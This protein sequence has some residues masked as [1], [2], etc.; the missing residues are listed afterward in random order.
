V[1]AAP[2]ANG[3]TTTAIVVAGFAAVVASAIVPHYG[4]GHRLLAGVLLAGLL[5]YVLF[6]I[7]VRLV[8]TRPMLGAGTIILA[9][10]LVIRLALRLSLETPDGYHGYTLYVV[11]LLSTAV[12]V[13]L[14]RILHQPDTGRPVGN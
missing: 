4:A 5:P 7:C 2:A 8:P 13:A 3:R 11:P 6:A 14:A 1:T 9:L 12:I 10:D